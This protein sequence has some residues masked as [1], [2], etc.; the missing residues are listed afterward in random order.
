MIP[1][2]WYLLRPGLHLLQ[3][4]CLATIGVTQGEPHSAMEITAN[5]WPAYSKKYA[6]EDIDVEA[7]GRLPYLSISVAL[8][9]ASGDV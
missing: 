6:S 1:R 8:P 9:P 7:L 5:L 3:G 2:N 4:Q